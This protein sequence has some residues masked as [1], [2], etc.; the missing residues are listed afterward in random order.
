[1][2]TIKDQTPI[3]YEVRR[4]GKWK[5]PNIKLPEPAPTKSG[6]IVSESFWNT[7]KGEWTD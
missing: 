2:A 6:M 4:E 7:C 3:Y 5:I 1:M